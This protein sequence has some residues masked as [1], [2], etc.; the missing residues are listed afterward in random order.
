MRKPWKGQRISQNTPGCIMVTNT[1]QRGTAC[2]SF[3]FL[4]LGC[5]RVMLLISS[6]R[7]QD[8]GTAIV[9]NVASERR[10][11]TE[12]PLHCPDQVSWPCPTQ[13]AGTCNPSRLQ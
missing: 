7:I 11:E 2:N 10:Q 13:E 6:S 3:Y 4:E 12:G 8:K 1:P 9:F 5:L